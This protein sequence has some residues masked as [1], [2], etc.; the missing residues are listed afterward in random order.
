M[1]DKTVG[2]FG[3]R[4]IHVRM[5]ELTHRRLKMLTVREDSTIQGVVEELI[6]KRLAEEQ[7]EIK[8]AERRG[9]V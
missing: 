8:R 5:N 6:E 2:K 7:T 3:K 9:L 1:K 4:M